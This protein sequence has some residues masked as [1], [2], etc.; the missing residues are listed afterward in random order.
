MK[1][2]LET[3]NKFKVLTQSEYETLL[4]LSNP[5]GGATAKGANSSMGG[6]SI[7]ISAAAS[8]MANT[9]VSTPSGGAKPKFTL[10]SPGFSPIQG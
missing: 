3:G 1:D 9:S 8:S 2:Q 7:P 5:T 6:T 10:A 4:L